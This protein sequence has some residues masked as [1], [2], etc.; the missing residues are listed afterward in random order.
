MMGKWLVKALRR[1]RNCLHFG[2]E[3][4]KFLLLLLLTKAFTKI[5]FVI[6]LMTSFFVCCNYSSTFIFFSTKSFDLV[7]PFKKTAEQRVLVEVLVINTLV[8]WI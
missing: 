6:Y 5:M 2:L 4:G 3:G 8:D 1:D 7:Q